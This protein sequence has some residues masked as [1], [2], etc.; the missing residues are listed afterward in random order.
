MCKSCRSYV[1]WG[2]IIRGCYRRHQ[3]DKALQ[4]EE[5]DR[6]EDGV[7]AEA[8]SDDPTENLIPVVPTPAKAPRTRVAKDRTVKRSRNSKAI[9]T[10]RAPPV[11]EGNSGG[12]T[13]DIGGFTDQDDSESEAERRTSKLT[14]FR[15]RK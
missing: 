3:G 4:S 8:Q 9:T 13:F 5:S 12:E 15:Q 14:P 11:V 10:K 6:E 1:L 2:D 7:E